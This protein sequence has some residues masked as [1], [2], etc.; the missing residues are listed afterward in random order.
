MT[1]ALLAILLA[2]AGADTTITIRTSSSTL[3]FVPP[4]FSLKAGTRVRLRLENA[5]TL[6]HNIVFVRNE[7]DIDALAEAAARQGGDYVP[8][9]LKDRLLAFTTLAN[10]G[11]TVET[12]FVVPPPGEYPYV[13]LV[14]GHAMMMLGTLRSLR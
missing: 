2:G 11:E 13:C 7:T 8:A 1:G 4:A 3:E 5:G 6:P 12:S 10:P 9:A 14:S